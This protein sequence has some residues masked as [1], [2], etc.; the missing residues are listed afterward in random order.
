MTMDD[1]RKP[2]PPLVLLLASAFVVAGLALATPTADAHPCKSEDHAACNSHSCPDDGVYH[3]HIHNVHWWRDHGCE[4]GPGCCHAALVSGNTIA[5]TPD[6]VFCVTDTAGFSWDFPD[7]PV[8]PTG[9]FQPVDDLADCVIFL[10]PFAVTDPA[11][12]C[13]FALGLN[14]VDAPAAP[15]LAPR[16]FAWTA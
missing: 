10:V 14:E 12:W 2:R 8:P 7:W 3:R 9:P 5:C 6:E 1:L 4:S 16:P 13:A 11:A 15:P